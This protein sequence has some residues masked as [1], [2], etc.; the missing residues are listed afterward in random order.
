VAFAVKEDSEANQ[1]EGLLKIPL[2][3]ADNSR[4]WGTKIKIKAEVVL[5]IK[6]GIPNSH[7]GLNKIRARD[8]QRSPPINN[9]KTTCINSLHSMASKTSVFTTLNMKDRIWFRRE[10]HIK[11]FPA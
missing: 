5:P 8:N 10:P 3:P 6:E 1:R 7:P 9:S 11:T 2:S 4:V